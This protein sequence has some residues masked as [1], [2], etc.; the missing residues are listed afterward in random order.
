MTV[1]P[2]SIMAQDAEDDTN[3]VGLTDAEKAWIA[4]H[5]VLRLTNQM[6][7]PPFD[8]VLGGEPAGY[9]IDYIN[10]LAE[11]IGVRIEFTNG[12]SWEELSGKVANKELDILHSV[13]RS[14]EREEFLE[15][16]EAYIA[17]PMV[18]FGRAGSDPINSI[19]DLSDKRIGVIEDFA[20][21]DIYK[22]D[23]PDFNLVI[24]ENIKEALVALSAGEID[25]FSVTLPI[26]N[27][28]ITKNFI[29]G[30]AVLGRD[31]LPEF[32]SNIELRFGVR[33]DWP[34][35]VPILEKGM[36]AISSQELQDLSNRWQQEYELN[37]ELELTAE[38][39]NWLA[40]NPVVQVVADPF[41]VPLELIDENGNISGI[42]GAYLD[43]IAEKLNVTFQWAGNK[44][45]PEGMAKVEAGEADVLSAI[46][47]TPERRRFLEF[48]DSYISLNN[49][50]FALDEGEFFG[51]MNGLNGRTIAQLKDFSVTEFI[52]QDY[53]NINII[54]VDTI[55]EALSL[56]SNG[57]ADAYIGDLTTTSYYMAAEGYAGLVVAGDAPYQTAISMGIRNELPLLASS[58]QKAIISMTEIEKIEISRNWMALRVEVSQNNELIYRIIA[59]SAIAL[60]AILSWVMILRREI[61]RRKETEKKLIIS[62]RQAHKANQ[63]KSTFLA[64]ISHELRTPLNAI[65]GFSDVMKSEVYGAIP[66]LKYREYLE[67]IHSSGNHLADV[68]KDLLD[69]SKIEAGKMQLAE[70]DFDI[71]ACINETVKMIQGAADAKEIKINNQLAGIEEPFIFYGDKQACKRIFINLLSNAVKFTKNGGDITITAELNDEVGRI[72]I[73][74]T[75]I[76]I[77][78]D[79]IEHVL[80]PFGQIQDDH[81]LNE[82][83]T[84]LGLAIVTQ[85]VTMHNCRFRLESEVGVGTTAI[86]ELDMDRIS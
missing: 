60:L 5:P 72:E 9:S 23:Y 31:H 55:G 44:D 69:L 85:L 51:N 75:G 78:E 1:F 7:W 54:E 46:V 25:V 38:E 19:N 80:T 37:P 86:I 42:S 12:Y 83:G 28:A 2:V 64:N 20:H 48:T 4:E 82:E 21:F 29:P 3:I 53:P 61:A 63:A 74:D 57:S 71:K 16:T 11:K 58:M 32:A 66:Q 62:Q 45:W 40:N 34:E 33:K 24:Q 56:V 14:P 68:I 17:L 49:V 6:D 15:F 73:K 59:I 18:Y 41:I 52:K 65:I 70:V 79:R 47:S 77:P 26:A 36:A 50:I 22:R 67:D 76:G 10:L 43:N 84:G 8:F 13:V 30:L 35:L 81:E 27:Y 39:R